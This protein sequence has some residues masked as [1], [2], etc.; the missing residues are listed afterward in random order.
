MKKSIIMS[1]AV[2]AGIALLSSCGGNTSKKVEIVDYSGATSFTPNTATSVSDTVLTLDSMKFAT[3][4]IRRYADSGSQYSVSVD[5]Y[6]PKNNEKISGALATYVGEVM[7]NFDIKPEEPVLLGVDSIVPLTNEQV[8]AYVDTVVKEFADVVV[9][10]AI[11]DSVIGTTAAVT[12]KPVYLNDSY[13]SYAMYSSIFL[14]GANALSDFYLQTYDLGSGMPMDFYSLVPASKQDAV[15]RQL[16]EVIAAKSGQT[17]DQYLASV[18]EWVGAD[19]TENWTVKNFPVYHVGLSD[20]GY[21]FCYPKYSIAPG[22]E[23]VGV[24]VVPFE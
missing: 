24:F 8:V 18:N 9:P 13:V 17:V 16:V 23:G 22:S 11:K 2:V 20:Q 1:A 10:K 12:A 14:G 15:R 6:V 19:K 7:N 3:E 4:N 5:L 21:V